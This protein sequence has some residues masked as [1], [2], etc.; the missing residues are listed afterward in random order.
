MEMN[1]NEIEDLDRYLTKPTEYSSTTEIEEESIDWNKDDFGE[2]VDENDWLLIAYFKLDEVETKFI[3][4]YDGFLDLLDKYGP[5]NL[6]TEKLNF[7]SGKEWLTEGEFN[8]WKPCI[9]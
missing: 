6:I 9:D 1:P 5:D 4:K 3:V 2:I 8:Q 7:I